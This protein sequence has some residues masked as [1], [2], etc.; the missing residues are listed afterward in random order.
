MAA[1]LIEPSLTM[2]RR[3]R[4]LARRV[5]WT[6]ALAIALLLRVFAIASAHATLVS[7]V[8]AAGSTV[9]T[10]PDRI[11]LV[12]SEPVEPGMAKVSLVVAGGRTITLSAS[13]DP[14]DVHA[15]IAP[16]GDAATLPPGEVRLMWHIVSADGH[17]VNGTFVFAIG[18]SAPRDTVPIPEPPAT[19][20]VTVW[21]PAIAGGPIIPAVLRGIGIGC[22]LALCGLLSFMVLFGASTGRPSQIALGLSIATPLFLGIHLLAWM[23]NASPD[24]RL[25]SAWMATSLAS[26]VGKVELWRTVLALLPLWALGLARRPGLALALTIP[27]LLVS[28]GV[29]HSAAIHPMLAIPFKAVH[30]AALAVWMGG[31][32]WIVVRERNE[33]SGLT[34]DIGRVSAVALWAVLLVTVSG[35]AQT[36]IL[37]QSTTGI[38]SAYGLVVIAKVVGLAALVGFGARH[39]RRLI[40]AIA[41]RGERAV[42][43]F[44]TWVGRELIVFCVVILLGGLLAY[45]SP[46][47]AG[48]A[49]ASAHSSETAP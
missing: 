40:P 22:L 29:G 10:M 1:R 48:D 5:G 24:H 36:L 27:P 7:S 31:L 38:R 44:Q 32:I 11:R 34:A 47:M 6:G 46:P 4:S 30:L 49:H 25:D 26:T 14:R 41:S 16:A 28:A 13:G 12:F 17:P 37:V 21:G 35:V 3:R 33:S 15:I 19:P 39:R 2:H 9:V 45:L 8:P 43:T 20:E 23:V 18:T 42:A